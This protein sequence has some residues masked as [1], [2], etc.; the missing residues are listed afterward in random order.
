MPNLW[1]SKVVLFSVGLSDIE[2]GIAA[3]VEKNNYVRSIS[4]EEE[5]E[6]EE[7][8][9]EGIGEVKWSGGRDK[10]FRAFLQRKASK[11]FS[12]TEERRD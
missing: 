1:A 6:T 5:E 7:K 10:T 3:K 11:E 9:N 8:G 2:K 12:Y 4:E